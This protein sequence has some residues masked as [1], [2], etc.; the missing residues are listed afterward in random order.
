MMAQQFLAIQATSALS[1][2]FFFKGPTNSFWAEI[3][4]ES[5]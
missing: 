4:L 2:P 1:E 5:K 3:Q